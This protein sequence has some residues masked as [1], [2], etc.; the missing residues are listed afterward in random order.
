MPATLIGAIVGSVLSGSV[1]TVVAVV[2][3]RYA[4]KQTESSIPRPEMHSF[5]PVATMPSPEMSLQK[6]RPHHHI[7]VHSP[8]PVF[9]RPMPPPETSLVPRH[10]TRVHSF[11]PV[12]NMPPPE[13]S[14]ERTGRRRPHH[15]TRVHSFEPVVFPPTMPRSET[16]L[17]ILPEGRRRP[18][19]RTRIYSPELVVSRPG[20][21]PGTS[22]D[23][24]PDPHYPVRVQVP[25][26]VP[27]FPP[28][29]VAMAPSFGREE[30][31]GQGWYRRPQMDLPNRPPTL[32]A[33]GVHG[34]ASG[35]RN[36]NRGTQREPESGSE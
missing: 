17:E 16:S 29:F 21:R 25:P 34:S 23:T 36:G 22:L 8:E 4:N 6:W 13:T 32:V 11:E 2:A 27:V 15:R 7:R 1:V 33:D 20:P 26:P 9:F 3:Q 31:V 5:E 18:R 10:P 19:H 30:P 35:E 28:G 24:P 14:L 12:A